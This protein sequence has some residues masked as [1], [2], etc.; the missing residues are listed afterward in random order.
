MAELRQALELS[1][2]SIGL[3]TCL[4]V[5]LYKIKGPNTSFFYVENTLSPLKLPPLCHLDHQ[6]F[7]K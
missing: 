2:D 7:K 1:E 3:V 5:K 4:F 6:T